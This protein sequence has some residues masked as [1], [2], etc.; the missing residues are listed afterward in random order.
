MTAAL[1]GAGI[2]GLLAILWSEWSRCRRYKA[3]YVLWHAYDGVTGP[4][5]RASG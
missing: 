5:R 1:I 2:L 4:N 3:V